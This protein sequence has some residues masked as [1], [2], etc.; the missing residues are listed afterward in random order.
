MKKRNAFTLIELL[1]IIVI[2]AIIAVITVPI[3][4]N[5]IEN[6]RKGA[7][8]DSA[9]GFKDSVNK[10]YVSKLSEEGNRDLKLDK[11]YTV[12]DGVISGAG[13]NEKVP[14]SG[15]VPSSGSLT[16]ENGVF[17]SGCLVIGDYAVTFNTDGTTSTEKGECPEVAATTEYGFKS[18]D[19]NVFGESDMM[20][21]T[22][23]YNVTGK[24]VYL[25]YELTNGE[26]AEGTVPEAC[27]YGFNGELCLKSGA[28]NFSTN[29]DKIISYFGY[30]ESTW[31]N[32]FNS[33]WV[34]PSDNLS[35]DID[36]SAVGCSDSN[37]MLW[38]LSNGGVVANGSD[39]IHCDVNAD[40]SALCNGSNCS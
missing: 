19:I 14:V 6:S 27:I 24:N 37:G 35:C 10:L 34:D 33:T 22:S 12:T 29:S 13:L 25:K 17:K 21:G 18:Y 31:N 5:I 2:L 39:G 7:A 16:Y 3:I 9:Y 8:Q 15:T 20:F 4:L 36:A 28:S 40:G 23:G 1:A 32:T 30:D 38:A 26:V 11:T